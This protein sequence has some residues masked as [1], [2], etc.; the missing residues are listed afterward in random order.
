MVRGLHSADVVINHHLRLRRIPR[1]DGYILR[2]D[3]ADGT[4][5]RSSDYVN[6]LLNAEQV[7]D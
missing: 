7:L 3:A 5:W 6:L 2:A 4:I 1:A